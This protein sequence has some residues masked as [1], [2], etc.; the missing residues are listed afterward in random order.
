MKAKERRASQVS[1]LY[2][3]AEIQVLRDQA[4]MAGLGLAPYIRMLTMEAA[5]SKYRT[6]DRVTAA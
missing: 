3:P 5:R 4:E 1:V 6:D 2:R